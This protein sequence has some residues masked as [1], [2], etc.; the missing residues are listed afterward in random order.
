[1]GHSRRAAQPDYNSTHAFMTTGHTPSPPA[2][3]ER[4]SFENGVA[5]YRLTAWSA[6]ADFLDAQVFT[7]RGRAEHR[8]IWRGQC[9]SDWMLDSSLDR[10]FRRVGYNGGNGKT[11]EQRSQE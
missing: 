7:N 9:R 4:V 10:L 2:R 3:W 11:L 5:T 1:M 8:F 6:F